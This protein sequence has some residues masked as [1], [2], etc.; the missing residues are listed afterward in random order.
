[1]CNPNRVAIP[2]AKATKVLYKL[3]RMAKCYSLY[4]PITM[5]D[6]N[7][8][9][10]LNIYHVWTK[11]VAITRPNINCG[12][13]TLEKKFESE[14]PPNA[15][16]VKAF[17]AIYFKGLHGSV[18]GSANGSAAHG[19]WGLFAADGTVIDSKHNRLAKDAADRRIPGQWRTIF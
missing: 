15:T 5:E 4:S 10:I 11:A 16:L 1:M 17:E 8:P 9:P 13:V 12:W 7:F 3:C 6:M 19:N 18:L 14:H 2:I